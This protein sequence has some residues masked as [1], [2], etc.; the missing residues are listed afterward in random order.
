MGKPI[1]IFENQEQLE[2]CLREWQHRLFLDGWLI[3]AHVED[4]I[5]NPDG[6]EVIDAAGYNT[7]VFESSQANIQLLSDELT[8]RTIRCS[9]IAWKRILCM[10]FYIA[11]M[12]GWDAR[13][14]PMRACIWMQPNTRS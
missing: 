4:K 12:T 11:S 5:M 8:K 13:V 1:D 10:N 14:G 6:E 9:N 2:E 7:F 3:L